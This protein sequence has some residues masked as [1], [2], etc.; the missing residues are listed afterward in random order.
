MSVK[1]K[2]VMDM[3]KYAIVIQMFLHEKS[4]LFIYEDVL[5][6]INNL[7]SKRGGKSAYI[8]KDF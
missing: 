4:L 8:I 3:N 5:D 6:F 7:R 1:D 2:N